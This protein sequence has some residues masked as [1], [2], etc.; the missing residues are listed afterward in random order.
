M[1]D[2]AS[3]TS[4]NAVQKEKRKIVFADEAGGKLCDIKTFDDDAASVEESYNHKAVIYD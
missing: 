2:E 3:D 1:S 4:G